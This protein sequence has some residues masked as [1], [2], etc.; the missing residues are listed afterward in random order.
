MRRALLPVLLLCAAAC[1]TK[2]LPAPLQSEDMLS[3]AA[4]HA[5]RMGACLTLDADLRGDLDKFA[6]VTLLLQE[7]E[8]DDC[9]TCPFKAKQRVD[10]NQGDE[11]LRLDGPDGRR[12]HLSYCGLNPTATYR[13]T[14]VANNLL[15]GLPGAGTQVF[16]AA[17]NPQ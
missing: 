11:R 10:L 17:P 2:G 4:P 7:L 12:L 15:P 6:G 8:L 9:P 14:A 5:G 1:G 13:W 16:L 3:L